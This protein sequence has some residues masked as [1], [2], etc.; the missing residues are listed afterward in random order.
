MSTTI[1]LDA[2]PW[3]LAATFAASW[4]AVIFDNTSSFDAHV[5]DALQ[6][7]TEQNAVRSL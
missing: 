6:I 1:A 2:A 3:F 5:E 4:L 7:L